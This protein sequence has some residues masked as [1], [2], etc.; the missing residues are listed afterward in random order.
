MFKSTK[1]KKIKKVLTIVGMQ[2]S[3]NKWKNHKNFEKLHSTC[4]KLTK[5]QKVP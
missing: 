1:K 4:K 2:K 5:M 3:I